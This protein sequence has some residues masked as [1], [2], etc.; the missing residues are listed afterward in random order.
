MTRKTSSKNGP[1][2]EE[3][4]GDF[5]GFPRHHKNEES[6]VSLNFGPKRMTLLGASVCLIASA[7]A[8][9]AQ[10]NQDSKSDGHQG[11]QI[12]VEQQQPN[13][14]V[15][16]PQPEVTVTQPQPQVKVTQ[17]KPEVSVEQPKPQ[18]QVQQAQPSV[19]VQQE[20]KPKVTVQQEG[21][22]Q[23]TMQREAQDQ[24]AQPSQA[25]EQ[26][27]TAQPEGIAALQ[28]NQVVGKTLYD[29]NNNDVG[30]IDSAQE[31]SSGNIQSV[32]LDVGG[33]LGIGAKRVSIPA[34]QVQL[35]G[36]RLTT[37]MTADQIRNLP[38]AGNQ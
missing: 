3:D 6:L 20:G 14:T 30:K 5:G 8:A 7:A 38:Q 15:R 37:S 29:R 35:E 19:Q 18:V 34:N 23:V 27:G 33:F 11:P 13:V 24:K 21:Q 25:Q 26:Q 9:N 12:K 10:S 2:S 1:W 36:G 16:Q 4:R 28:K 17:P 22:P 31:A 32:Q